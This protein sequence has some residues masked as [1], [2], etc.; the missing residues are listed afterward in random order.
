[1]LGLP[2]LADLAA[3]SATVRRMFLIDGSGRDLPAVSFVRMPGQLPKVTVSAVIG[4]ERGRRRVG[5]IAAEVPR[6]DWEDI[7]EASASFE[8]DFVAVPQDGNEYCLHPWVA[9]V[10]AADPAHDYLPA[11]VRTKTHTACSR[12]VAFGFAI[13]L[14]KRAV[15]LIP[16]C[17]AIKG[18]ERHSAYTLQTCAMFEG[19]TLAAAEMAGRQRLPYAAEFALDPEIRWPGEPPAKGSEAAIKLW[20]QR[21]EGSASPY[22]FVASTIVGQ[23]ANRV[24]VRGVVARRSPE[25]KD[26]AFADAEQ[27]WTRAPNDQF[28]LKLFTI[29]SFE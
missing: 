28:R 10:E 15:D 4:D 9:T 3:K 5:T 18:G 16:A 11:S 1:M 12:G 25:Y 8:R 7:L 20:A 29:G 27:V 17:N 14:A 24:L 23:T 2:P 13:M 22:Y 21:F 6:E 26:Y 19:D